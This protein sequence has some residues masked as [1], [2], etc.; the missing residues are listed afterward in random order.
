MRVNISGL[1]QQAWRGEKLFEEFIKYARSIGCKQIQDEIVAD[2]EQSKLLA[3]WWQA[4][5]DGAW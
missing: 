2:E 4:K 3:H 1:K 5:M